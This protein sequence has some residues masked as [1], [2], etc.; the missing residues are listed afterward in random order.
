MAAFKERIE[1]LDRLFELIPQNEAFEDY[2]N[3]SALLRRMVSDYADCATPEAKRRA[4]QR[5]LQELVSSGRI[6]KVDREEKPL[7]FRRCNENLADDEHLWAYART[8]IANAVS[9]ELPSG[10]LDGVLKRLQSREIDVQLDEDKLRVVSDT[11]RL[12]PAA[13]RADTLVH[14]LEALT[15]GR[16]LNIGYRDAAD[17]V[18]KPVVH[19]QALLQRG[20]RLYLFALKNDEPEPVRMYALHRI[21]SSSLSE[22]PARKAEHFRLSDSIKRSNA[23]F[24]DGTLIELEILARGYVAGLLREC[25]LSADQRVEDEEEGSGFDLRITATLPATGQLLRWLLGCGDNIVVLKPDN[26]R[27]TVSAQ[28]AKIAALYSTAE[29]REPA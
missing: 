6:E 7:R 16:A 19:P 17:K 26:L 13:I 14:I 8:A 2:P 9:T 20:P 27:A 18:T 11:L 25:A 1:R 10:L 23:D 5:D 28:A 21:T 4:I 22:L 12:Q 29:R 24:G 15:S 3:T